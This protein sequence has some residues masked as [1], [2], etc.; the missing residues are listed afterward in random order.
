MGALELELKQDRFELLALLLAS[1]GPNPLP[2]L[3]P[4]GVAP[5]P[6]RRYADH[7]SKS[8]ARFG[9]GPYS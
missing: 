1:I 9:L 6:I 8:E 7:S 2:T 4:L 5:A 3:S